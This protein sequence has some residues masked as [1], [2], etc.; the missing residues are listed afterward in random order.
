MRADLSPYGPP[1]AFVQWFCIYHGHHVKNLRTKPAVFYMSFLYINHCL[2]MSPTDSHC[3]KGLVR[4]QIDYTIGA[5][6]KAF[7]A[8]EK[9]LSK[10]FVGKPAHVLK[11]DSKLRFNGSYIG[12]EKWYGQCEF[13]SKF[14]K[15]RRH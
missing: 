12:S 6:K 5:G 11:D 1:E 7:I 10:I 9:S 14:G 13:A 15:I 3:A 2:A 4:M 8:L